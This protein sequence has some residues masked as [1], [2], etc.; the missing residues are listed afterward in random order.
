MTNYADLEEC[1]PPQPSTSAVTP[2]SICIILQ[3]ILS[4]I[5]ILLIIPTPNV[6]L[7]Q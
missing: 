3:I 6:P 4:L 7:F 1:Y 2:S 5:Q